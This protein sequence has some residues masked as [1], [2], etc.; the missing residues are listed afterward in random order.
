MADQHPPQEV[1]HD[2]EKKIAEAAK[3]QE[4]QKKAAEKQARQAA[5]HSAESPAADSRSRQ[6]LESR[7]NHTILENL[8]IGMLDGAKVVAKPLYTAGWM[9][10]GGLVSYALAGLSPFILGG[11]LATGRFF[12]NRAANKPFTFKD[13]RKEYAK[14]L[15][16]GLLYYPAAVDISATPSIPIKL[17]KFFGYG[18][19]TFMAADHFVDPFSPKNH[20]TTPPFFLG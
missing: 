18:A 11:G 17:L 12:L 8:G 7:V 2:D 20:T 4:A 3:K 1:K 10:G 16:S 6:N 5:K 19:P 13:F 9:T 15:F 14:G